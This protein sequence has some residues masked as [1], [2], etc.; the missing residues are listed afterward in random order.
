N[1]EAEESLTNALSMEPENVVIM[2]ELGYFYSKTG[3]TK[4]ALDI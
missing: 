3:K 1:S 4:E 2:S